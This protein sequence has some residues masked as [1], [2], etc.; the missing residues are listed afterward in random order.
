MVM[1]AVVEEEVEA[2]GEERMSAS[3]C[4]HPLL[5]RPTCCTGMGPKDAPSPSAFQ[6]GQTS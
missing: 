4:T 1:V 6:N 5:Q 2:D 3:P